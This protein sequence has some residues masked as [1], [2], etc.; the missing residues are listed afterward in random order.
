MSDI[1]EFVAEAQAAH[2]EAMQDVIRAILDHKG[3][4]GHN[5]WECQNC[6]NPGVAY[7]E[8]YECRAD[9][10]N[11]EGI[12]ETWTETEHMWREFTPEEA[13][14]FRDEHPCDC[15]GAELEARA[16]ELL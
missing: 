14:V 1:N 16:R 5:I 9:L 8:E 10:P 3:W 4:M 7:E 15:G 2:I 13:R 11:K 6:D 12:Y